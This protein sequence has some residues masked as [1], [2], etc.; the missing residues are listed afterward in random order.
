LKSDKGI[1]TRFLIE[2]TGYSRQQLTRL[3]SQYKKTGRIKWEPCRNYGFSRKNTEKDIRLLIKTDEQYDAPC[4]HA[5]KKLC[6]RAYHV[7]GE[8]E[9]Q[10]LGVATNIVHVF[11]H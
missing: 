7:F 1:I 6:E 5:I 9:Y 2:V 11:S 4:G 10:I 3:I 8:S